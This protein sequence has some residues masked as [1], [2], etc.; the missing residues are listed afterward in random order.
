MY[1]RCIILLETTSLQSSGQIGAL[2]F[3][4]GVAKLKITIDHGNLIIFRMP[5]KDVAER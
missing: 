2:P 1:Q 5:S 4:F 3:K